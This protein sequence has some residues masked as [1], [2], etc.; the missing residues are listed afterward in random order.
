MQF[1]CENNNAEGVKQLTLSGL[2]RCFYYDPK[3]VAYA[4]TLGS[5]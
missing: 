3:V 1:E 5:N 4:P 2:D